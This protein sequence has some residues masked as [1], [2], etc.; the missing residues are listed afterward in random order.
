MKHHSQRRGVPPRATLEID[1]SAVRDNFAKVVAKAAPAQVMSVVKANAYGLGVAQFARA[2][3]QAGCRRF[4]VASPAESLELS[5]LGLR[6]AAVQMLSSVLPE[7]IAPMLE[8]GVVLPV[9][10][11]EEARLISRAAA[12]SGRPARVHFKIDTGMGRLGIRAEEAADAIRAAAKM[13]MLSCEGLMTHFPVASDTSNPITARQIRTMKDL[14]AALAADGVRFKY[15]HCAASDGINGFAAAA[16]PPFTLVRAGLDLHGG[17]S[18]GAERLGLKQVFT[19][20]ARIAQARDLPA[21]TAVGYGGTFVLKRRSRVA[22]VAAGY[23]DGIPLAL[24]NRGFALVNGIRC[25]FIGRVSMDY[26]AI[27]V[28]RAGNVSAGDETVLLGRD[29][30]S[31]VAPWDWA[32]AKGTHPHDILCAIGNRVARIYLGGRS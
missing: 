18:R 29:G 17:F 6:G 11:L 13:P 24:S 16:R 9:T 22:I 15:V 12:R 30:G 10:G 21:G 14:V 8:C 19:L 3:H 32:K 26:S 27:D 25:P 28:S 5:S 1:L 7:E 2:L 31:A 20:K 23:A 4:G